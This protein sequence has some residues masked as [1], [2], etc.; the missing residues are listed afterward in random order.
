MSALALPICITRSFTSFALCGK[1]VVRDWLPHTVIDRNLV[2]VV[3]GGGGLINLGQYTNTSI[4]VLQISVNVQ[5]SAPLA[6]QA[7]EQA[8]TIISSIADELAQVNPL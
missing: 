8:T 4:G 6:S 5:S 7:R 2:D 3:H 1:D